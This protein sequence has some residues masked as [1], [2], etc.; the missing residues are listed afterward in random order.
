MPSGGSW[1]RK[2]CVQLNAAGEGAD[3]KVSVG[4]RNLRGWHSLILL[5]R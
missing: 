4:L 5:L 2:V 1:P 3:L